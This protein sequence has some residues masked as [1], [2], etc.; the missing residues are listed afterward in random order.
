MTID[1]IDVVAALAVGLITAGVALVFIPAGLVVLGV[2]LLAYAIAV[3]RAAPDVP[4]PEE[5]L[6]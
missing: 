3:M 4:R 2:L 5:E 6:S 1:P